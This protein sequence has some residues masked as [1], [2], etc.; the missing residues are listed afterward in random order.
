MLATKPFPRGVELFE[1]PGCNSVR[2]S[3]AKG[4]RLALIERVARR[5]PGVRAA[6][7]QIVE[8]SPEVAEGLGLRAIQLAEAAP[9]RPVRGKRLLDMSTDEIYSSLRGETPSVATIETE[10]KTPAKKPAAGKGYLKMSSDEI[11]EKLNVGW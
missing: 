5:S 7:R 2:E 4:A 3:L 8:S 6:L 9:R 11:W 10:P 1:A